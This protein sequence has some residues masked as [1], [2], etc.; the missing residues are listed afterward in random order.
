MLTATHSC[1]V[2]MLDVQIS[3]LNRY[4]ID[5]TCTSYEPALVLVLRKRL[6]MPGAGGWTYLSNL[7]GFYN[8]ILLLLRGD[9]EYLSDTC[10]RIEGKVVLTALFSARSKSRSM[11]LGS[12][13]Q[14][15]KDLN[16]GLFLVSSG[17]REAHRIQICGS[18][19]SGNALDSQLLEPL[20]R[21]GAILKV[22]S[23][24]TIEIVELF[25]PSRMMLVQRMS[26]RFP[27]NG[28]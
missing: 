25:T 3:R 14:R 24:N 22:P 7:G 4:S 16:I 21:G 9:Q 6:G 15:K 12:R 11:V 18:Y 2:D 10:M 26:T 1:T 27:C 23:P 28:C 20:N 13:G 8:P 19:R 5:C 17:P